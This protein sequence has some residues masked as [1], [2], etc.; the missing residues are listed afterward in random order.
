MNKAR[1]VGLIM[2][3]A[4]VIL[5]FTFENDGIDFLSGFFGGGG[6]AILITGSF[7]SKNRAT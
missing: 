7:S 4:A 5:P 1:I 6:L 3:I 2:I